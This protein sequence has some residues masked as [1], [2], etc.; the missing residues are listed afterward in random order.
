MEPT[1]GSETAHLDAT[2]H[3]ALGDEAGVEPIFTVVIPTHGRPRALRSCLDALAGQHYPR[4]QFEVVVVDDESPGAVAPVVAEFDD[5]LQVSS[6]RQRRAGPATARNRGA[7]RARGRYLAFL[8]DDCLAE[9]DWLAS[10]ESVFLAHPRGALVGGAIGN[11]Y[12][13]NVYAEVGELI[14]RVLLERY[15]PEPGGIYFFRAANL[16]VRRDEFCQTGGFDPSFDTAEDREFCDRW[17]HGGGVMIQAPSAL[18]LH[19]SPLDLRGF[20]HRHYRYGRG[21]YRFHRVRRQR[22]SGRFHWAYVWFYAFV[23]HACVFSK[24]SV[25]AKVTLVA[26]WQACNVLGFVAGFL[27]DVRGAARTTGAA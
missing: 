17:L 27:R 19:A 11:P 7:L 20:L 22:G 4:L 16:A 25:A 8:D 18:V 1:A 15:R 26:A 14:L 12:T 9:P 3:E 2:A 6:W 21:A 23:L 10:L 13:D 5:R 24:R